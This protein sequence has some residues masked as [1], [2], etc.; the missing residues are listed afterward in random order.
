MVALGRALVIVLWTVCFLGDLAESRRPKNGKSRRRKQFRKSQQTRRIV[1]G[2]ISN[3][4]KYPF[5]LSLRS[6]MKSRDYIPLHTCGA[7]LIH[8][9]W[10][11]TA[12][13]CVSQQ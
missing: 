12:A 10:A 11:L 2:M 3:I 6:S 1:G 5:Q 9:S 13:H 4:D 8:R 7:A